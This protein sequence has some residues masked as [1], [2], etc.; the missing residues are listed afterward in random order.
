MSVQPVNAA[1]DRAARARAQTDRRIHVLVVVSLRDDWTHTVST[2]CFYRLVLKSESFMCVTVCAWRGHA[3]GDDVLLLPLSSQL[4][5]L[6]R[7]LVFVQLTGAKRKTS[8]REQVFPDQMKH[9]ILYG[10]LVSS[11]QTSCT[12]M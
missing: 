10:T 5:L 2:S 12:R 11:L 1:Q 4:S 8:R 3:G 6:V 7:V 9:F